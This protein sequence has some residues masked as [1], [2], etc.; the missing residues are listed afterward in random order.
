MSNARRLDAEHPAIAA[1]RTAPLSDLPLAPEEIEA[2]AAAQ[3]APVF[4]A[5]ADVVAKLPTSDS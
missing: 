4:V 2:L 5:H 1:L 3:Q